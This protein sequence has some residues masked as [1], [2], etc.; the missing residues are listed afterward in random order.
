MVVLALLW[1]DLGNCPKGVCHWGMC[2]YQHIE[3]YQHEHNHNH[4][5]EHQ[6]KIK[7]G[8]DT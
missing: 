3:K 5:H 8:V 2:Q 1:V 6:L 7:L 4:E